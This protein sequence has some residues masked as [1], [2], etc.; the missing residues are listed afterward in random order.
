MATDFPIQGILDHLV[1]RIVEVLPIDAAGVTLI[2]PTTDPH[3]VAASD[4]SAMRFERLQSELGEGPGLAAYTADRPV[5]VPN[6]FED[7]R[8][9]PVLRSSAR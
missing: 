2:T 4:E 6:L 8:F 3:F 5:S 7:R 1:H 9:P